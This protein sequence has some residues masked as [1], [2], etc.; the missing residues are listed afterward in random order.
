MKYIQTQLGRFP[1]K[2]QF[3]YLGVKQIDKAIAFE[4]LK[5]VLAI[6]ENKHVRVSVA[7]G[8]LLGIIRD[9]DFI[10]WD[11]DIDL[12]V[13][14]EDAELFKNCLWDLKKEGFELIRSDRCD[15]LFSIQRNG[16][17]IDFYIMEK[18]TPEIR[19]DLGDGFFLDK[20]LVNL[21]SYPFKDISIK[22]PEEYEEYL[23]LTYGDWKTPV[24]YANFNLSKFQ[25]LKQR[26]WAIIKNLPPRPI[27]M[28]LLKK[29]HKKDFDKFLARCKENN[30]NL[31]YS[32]NY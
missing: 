13:L 32:V 26:I 18:I 5:T 1:Y 29:H 31:K 9:G 17:Y 21:I 7:Y 20:H 12:C 19:S 10:D 25:I 30:I 8:T 27:R 11:E 6:L 16:E 23:R 28:K 24:K 4:N 15:H 2:S 22:I 3:I 14:A